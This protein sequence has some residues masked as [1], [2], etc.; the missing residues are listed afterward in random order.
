M[1]PYTA[2]IR[3]LLVED[4]PSQL[5][6]LRAY[7][8]ATPDLIVVGT[9]TTGQEAVQSTIRLRPN[10]VAMDIHLPVFDGYEATRQIMRHQPTPIVLFSSSAGNAEQR[11]MAALAA[12]ALAVV[13][14][15][16]GPA[17]P[18]SATDREHLI[19]TLRLMAGV[20][21]VTRHPP[22]AKPTPVL[23]RTSNQIDIV[24][25]AASTGGPAALQTV[26]TD[27]GAHMPVPVVIAQHMAVGFAQALADWLASVVPQPIHVVT[28]EL[29]LTPGHVYIPAD[30]LHL[31]IKQ[32]GT[33]GVIPISDTDRYCPSAD[34][35][36]ASVVCHYG[37][38]AIG[39]IL[40]GMGE[41]G[42]QGLAEL[43]AAGAITFGQDEASCVV[44][45][46]PKAAKALGAVRYELPLE[47]L[48]LSVAALLTPVQPKD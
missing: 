41:D 10:V 35:L 29:S 14:K 3:V 32:P 25:I 45:G 46:M 21:V 22:R 19:R 30:N 13:R 18:A 7:L 12:G 38:R 27:L 31:V 33:V 43:A 9:A 23:H 42:A 1:K 16:A 6:L 47:R 2:P 28:R 8:A 15:P 20:K 17:D 44:Y 40:T 11:A 37:A 4:S 26:L 24:A 36:F 39:V 5:Q 34:R 48:G